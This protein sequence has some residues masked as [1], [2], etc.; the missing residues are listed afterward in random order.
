M[1]ISRISKTVVTQLLTSKTAG[2]IV[3]GYVP[4]VKQYCTGFAS[5]VLQRSKEHMCTESLTNIKVYYR[6][7]WEGSG[8]GN[9]IQQHRYS[10]TSGNRL[11]W[12][13]AS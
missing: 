2:E 1:T 3:K 13:A 9:T 8:K 4:S 12:A 10:G 5:Q 11:Q 7:L 6:E